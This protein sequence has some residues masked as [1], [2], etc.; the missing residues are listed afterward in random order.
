MNIIDS[1]ND[2][3]RKSLVASN[4]VKNFTSEEKNNLLIKIA[5]KIN[6]DK[7]LILNANQKDI[8]IAS[9]TIDKAMLDRLALNSDRVDSIINSI[10]DIVLLE[11]PINKVINKNERPNGMLVERVSVPLGV[12]GIIYE[13]RP[14][15]TIDASV[16]CL[17]AGNS[18]ILRGGKESYYSNLQLVTSARNALEESNYDK[19]II[20]F[21]ETT[22]RDAVDYMLSEMS[23]YIDVIIPRG[24][25]G[26][27]KKVQDKAKIPVIG[28]LDGICHV[29]VDEFADKDKAE[30][31]VNNSKLRRTGICG[32]AETLLVHKDC[33]DSHLPSIINILES[34]GCEIRGDEMI[35]KNYPD[36][37][38]AN[39]DDWKTE[40]LDSII[41]IKI[42]ADVN[43]AIKHITKY[44]SNHT[45]SIITENKENAELFL[46]HV[47]SAIVMHNTST[48]FADG[49]EFGLGAEIGIATGKLH[50][51]GPVGLEGLT[52]YKYKVRGDGQIRP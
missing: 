18:V 28:H 46:N 51:R 15:V 23:Q 11:D 6:S 12:I 29:Y 2:I 48:Q 17:K 44:G 34:G 9:E 26:L 33:I 27:V 20:Q 14:N 31:V 45:E 50:A 22:D 10:N 36:L 1:L 8:S 43:D 4:Q 42:V 13:S 30:Q 32:A 38:K 5:E 52:T 49:G 7:E 16:L 3:G 35:T 41:S 39:E 40:Y 24:G 21:I 47:G 25:K 19:N 37:I